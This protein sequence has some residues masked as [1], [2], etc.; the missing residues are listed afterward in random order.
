VILEAAPLDPARRAL[1]VVERKGVG[2]PDTLCD[3]AAE[4]FSR[5]LSR[6]YLDAVGHVLH[7]NVDKALLVGGRT[8]VRFG[9]GEWMAPIVVTLAGR[10]TT[11]LDGREVPVEGIAR[12]AL[13]EALAPVRCLDRQ[14]VELRVAVHP[15]A[16]ELRELVAAKTP[17]ANDTSIGVGFAPRTPLEEL[18]LAVDARL[19]AEMHRDPGC[20]LG[21]DVKVMAVREGDALRLTVAVAMLAPRLPGEAVYR[22]ATE[23]VRALAL[24]EA[25]ERGFADAHVDVN[26]ADKPGSCYLTVSGTS[27]ECGDDGQVGRGNRASGLI[28]P[29]RPMTLEAYAG[30]NPTSHVGKLLSVAAERAAQRCARLPGVR[31]AECVLVSRIGGALDEPQACGVRLDVPA[32]AL[33]GLRDEAEAILAAELAS[34]PTLW[35]ELIGS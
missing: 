32:A 2:H 28:T 35:R 16:A 18:A 15:G 31:A 22:A 13:D 25:R 34:L 10:A 20:P 17:R 14:R 1:E 26:A 21:E 27:A 33:P 4:A 24:A 29:M 19:L 12:R 7:H 3:A 11:G 5:G 30:K 9:G 6:H 23:R 8:T